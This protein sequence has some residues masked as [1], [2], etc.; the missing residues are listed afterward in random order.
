MYLEFI[1]FINFGVLVQRFI[2]LVFKVLL[3]LLEQFSQRLMLAKLFGF[4]NFTWS[5]VLLNPLQVVED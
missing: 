4:N 3:R 2:C 1:F 5:I